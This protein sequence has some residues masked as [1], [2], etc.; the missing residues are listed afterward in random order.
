MRANTVMPLALTSASSRF[1]VCSGSKSLG[2]TINPS[3]GI[4]GL[5]DW[6]ALLSIAQPT[7]IRI[8][9]AIVAAVRFAAGSGRTIAMPTTT[10]SRHDETFQGSSEFEDRYVSI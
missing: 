3:A 2:T 5:D 10:D 4:F 8:V 6:G 9:N 1:I 7:R